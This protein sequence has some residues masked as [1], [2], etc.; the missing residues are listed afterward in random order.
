M[1]VI[2]THV[3]DV[4]RY[5][6]PLS[7]ERPELLCTKS[8][9]PFVDI[10]MK[11]LRDGRLTPADLR[12]SSRTL[13]LQ[14]KVADDAGR[15]QLAEN[16]RRAAELAEFDDADILDFYNSMRPSLT[17]KSD[18]MATARRLEEKSA[19]RCARLVRDAAEVYE[20]RSLFKNQSRSTD[21]AQQE[22]G[23]E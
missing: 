16:L 23:A 5:D 15:P 20:R 4:T 13:L 9:T 18:M 3:P 11:N 12:I 10:T 1:D 21:G 7:T 6:Y 17:T 8:G 22:A 2:Q 14:A 19:L